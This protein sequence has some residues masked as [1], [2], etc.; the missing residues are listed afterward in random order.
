MYDLGRVQLYVKVTII[1]HIHKP[2]KINSK[3]NVSKASSPLSQNELLLLLALY[4]VN[5][6]Y[7]RGVGIAFY[8]DSSKRTSKG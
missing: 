4:L 8:V 6:Q 5:F 1:K 2:T 7:P 3:S